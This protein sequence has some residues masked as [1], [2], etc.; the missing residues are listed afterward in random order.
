MTGQRNPPV[1]LV[2]MAGSGKSTIGPL[3]ARR[4]GVDFVDTDREVERRAGCSVGELFAREGEEAFRSCE[5]SVLEWALSRADSVVAT[6]GGVVVDPVNRSRLEGVHTVWLAASRDRLLA[7]VGNGSGRPL[8]TGNP[9]ERVTSLLRERSGWY[10][11]VA[12]TTVDTSERTP[13]EVVNAIL[14]AL[15][16]P[17][18]PPR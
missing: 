9:A 3:L 6:G 16:H 5:R 1:V 2:G 4:L 10:L 7:R 18:D 11:E 15:D 8:L 13:A 12:E 17:S 14:D